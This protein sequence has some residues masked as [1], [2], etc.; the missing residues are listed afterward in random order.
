MTENLPSMSAVGLMVSTGIEMARL[1]SGPG[2]PPTNTVGMAGKALNM[3]MK[4]PTTVMEGAGKAKT[5]IKKA[6]ARGKLASTG[7]RGL[8]RMVMAREE[9]RLDCKAVR[10]VMGSRRGV[11]LAAT[12]GEKASIR[13]PTCGGW[14]WLK[15]ELVAT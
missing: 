8:K 9:P 7:L 1:Y 12:E 5:V 10:N 6:R 15:E 13:A 14:P 2:S 4:K 3:A 11:D